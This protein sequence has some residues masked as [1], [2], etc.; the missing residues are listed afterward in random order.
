MKR[1]CE[2]AWVAGLFEGE[3]S[4]IFTGK[5][6]VTLV[7]A[8]TDEDVLRKAAAIAEVGAVR[9]PYQNKGQKT[10]VYWWQ[11]AN[12]IEVEIFLDQVMPWLGER[13]LAKA[14]GALERIARIPDHKKHRPRHVGAQGER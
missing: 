7:I 9:G 4:I 14:V 3:G 6:S 10:P 13:R 11:I 1:D 8:L 12:C 5:N 2:W